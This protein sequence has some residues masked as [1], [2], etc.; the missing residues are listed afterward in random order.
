[1][2]AAVKQ[3]TA[4]VEKLSP[5]LENYLK[6]IFQIEHLEGAA[7][8]GSIAE[9]ANVSPASVTSALKSLQKLGYVNYKPYKL[10]R[11]T[12]NGKEIAKRVMHTQIVLEEFFNK[13]LHMD[14]AKAKKL[15]CDA[16]HVFDE[17]TFLQIRKLTYYFIHSPEILDTWEEKFHRIYEAKREEHVK[18]NI[19]ELF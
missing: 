18:K 7:R 13:V 14:K 10:V 5:I 17:E 9:K 12:E 11:L 4:K 19:K 2:S 1:M 8:M 16:E 6:V 15:A 3:T